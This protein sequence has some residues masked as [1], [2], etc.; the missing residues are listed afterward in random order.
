VKHTPWFEGE[1]KPIRVG[2]Y[3]RRRVPFAHIPSQ[4]KTAVH[5]FALFDGTNWRTEARTI[6]DAYKADPADISAYQDLPWQGLTEDEAREE[7][8]LLQ[9]GVACN[10]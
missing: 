4:Q 5:R 7:A 2:V 10:S 3:R 1:I 6:E 8:R 9:E